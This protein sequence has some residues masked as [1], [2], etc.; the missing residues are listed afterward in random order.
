MAGGRH[1]VFPGGTGRSLVSLVCVPLT[2]ATL[3]ISLPVT[4]AHNLT[5][6]AQPSVPS[7]AQAGQERGEAPLVEAKSPRV[8]GARCPRGLLSWVGNVSC[9]HF[10]AWVLCPP[11]SPALYAQGFP[12]NLCYTVEASSCF[13]CVSESC[14][15]SA[16]MSPVMLDWS[17]RYPCKLRV[18]RTHRGRR[19]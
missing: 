4:P 10:W 5:A 18:F 2:V 12:L 8:R 9:C 19:S 13:Q 14:L 11:N 17:Q 1:S 15:L 7:S 16:M 3:G 6:S